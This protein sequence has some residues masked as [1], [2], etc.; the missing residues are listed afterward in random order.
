MVTKRMLGAMTAVVALALAAVGCAPGGGA[1]RA[2]APGCDKTTKLDIATTPYQDSLVMMLGDKLGWYRQAC[3]DV[4][5]VNVS[6]S[7]IMSTVSGGQSANV[8]W[9][10]LSGVL[11]T[12]HQ[13]PDLVYLYPWDVF[14]EGNAIIARADS[15]LKSADEYKA[16]GMSEEQAVAAV[17]D[18]WRGRQVV[19]TSNNVRSEILETALARQ[20][21]P[22]DWVSKVDLAPDQG[23]AVFL[24]GTGD[25]YVSGIPQRQRLVDEGYKVLLSGPQ[26]ASP[27]LNGYLVKRQLWEQNPE[28]LLKL[29]QITFMSI[30]YT[31]ANLDEVADYISDE[32]SKQSGSTFT[33]ENFKSYW[34]KLEVYPENAGQAQ[35]M[36][37][38][39][40]GIGYWKRTW[41]QGNFYV[42]NIAKSIPEPVPDSAFLG[43][44]VQERYLKEFGPDETGWWTTTGSLSD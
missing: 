19:T 11:T 30:R 14:T 28:A 31:N 10:A 5:F 39:E 17:V 42:T 43:T 21:K 44:E 36:M 23:L 29:M 16:E 1:D 12:Y 2:P 6:Y 26:I 24:R 22:T 41:D 8:A 13:D 9:N 18:S 7:A 15:G 40:N 37:F 33:A 27:S 25:L 35:Q 34:N 20:G 32:Y 3:L 4:S 38:D